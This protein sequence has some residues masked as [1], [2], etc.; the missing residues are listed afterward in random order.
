[1]V[2]YISEY[3]AMWT[4]PLEWGRNIEYVST[5][6]SGLFVVSNREIQKWGEKEGERKGRAENEAKTK[7]VAKNLSK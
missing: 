3:T 7:W 2:L 1:M 6:S 5:V 4:L